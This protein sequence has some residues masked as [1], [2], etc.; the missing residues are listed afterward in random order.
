MAEWRYLLLLVFVYLWVHMM[1][2]VAR[3][4]FDTGVKWI[5]I[6]KRKPG[7]YPWDK[8]SYCLRWKLFESLCGHSLHDLRLIGGS[9]FLPFFY[10][11]IGSKIGAACAFTPQA[12]TRRWWNPTWW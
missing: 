7:L 5:L 12:R 10:N 8:S 1:H 6:G 9:A 4:I 2:T 11:N 3:F